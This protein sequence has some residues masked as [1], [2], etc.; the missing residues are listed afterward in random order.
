VFGCQ[1]Q[2]NRF[3]GKTRLKNIITL[4]IIG[5]SLFEYSNYG[6]TQK[7]N[8]IAIKF[9]T[10]DF[11]QSVTKLLNFKS[12]TKFCAWRPYVWNRQACTVV[13]AWQAGLIWEQV[14]G[15]GC[16]VACLGV[17]GLPC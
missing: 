15:L 2:W 8:P 11:E 4:L 10:V 12:R 1:Y 16:F 17:L 3:P 9:V 7:L 14:W 6:S 13:W 5:D